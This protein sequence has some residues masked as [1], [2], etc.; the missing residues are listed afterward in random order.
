MQSWVPGIQGGAP[1]C[2][3][4]LLGSRPC[5]PQ[6]GFDPMREEQKSWSQCTLLLGKGILNQLSHE[7]SGQEAGCAQEHITPLLEALP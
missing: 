5:G 2:G 7:L 1:L 4:L 6:E 3:W